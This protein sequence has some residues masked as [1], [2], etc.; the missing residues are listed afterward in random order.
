MLLIKLT[1]PHVLF[2]YLS[3]TIWVPTLT[4]A[5]IISR[6][7]RWVEAMS[8]V[9]VWV[10]SPY[11]AIRPVRKIQR[12]HNTAL[13]HGSVS[14]LVNICNWSIITEITPHLLVR[15]FI[16]Q[17]CENSHIGRPLYCIYLYKGIYININVYTHMCYKTSGLVGS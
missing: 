15:N 9:H 4:A 13:E 3:A 17:H 14:H 8:K 12:L 11:L 7:T 5:E 16:I 6:E 10:N 2:T 1:P